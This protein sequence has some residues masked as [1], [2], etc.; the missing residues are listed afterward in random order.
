MPNL[1][2]REQ[3]IATVPNLKRDSVE[4]EEW[5]GSVLIRELTGAERDDVELRFYKGQKTG[6]FRG[7]RVK[8]CLLA[9]IKEDGNPLFDEKKD[10]VILDS[11]SA[12]A[13]DK[14]FMKIAALSG[15]N[16]DGEKEGNAYGT[17]LPEKTG[18]E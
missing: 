16:P 2:T 15:L 7:V 17:I 11:L 5:G 3:I 8:V 13:L 18:L 12:K 1:L 6:D 14:L 10:A 4:I 9:C